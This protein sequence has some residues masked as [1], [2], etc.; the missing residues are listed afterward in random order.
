MSCYTNPCKSSILF[1][2]EL[3]RH[4]TRSMKTRYLVRRFL[5]TFYFSFLSPRLLFDSNTLS[6]SH[7]VKTVPFW[8]A[9]TETK[10]TSNTTKTLYSERKSRGGTSFILNNSALTRNITILPTFFTNFGTNLRQRNL[11]P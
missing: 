9:S 4:I 10:V 11:S 3:I 5:P 1:S 7:V 2:Y 6:P 8:V